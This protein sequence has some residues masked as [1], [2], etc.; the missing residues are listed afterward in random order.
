MISEEARADILAHAKEEFPNECCGVVAIVRGRERYFRCANIS[1]DPQNQFTMSPDDFAVADD[2]GEITHIAH[3]H[4]HL[5]PIPSEAD[6]VSCEA[7]G[8]PW[9]IVNP[10]TEEWG[11]CEPCGYE[12]PLVGRQHVWGVMDCWT[13]VRDWYRRE[14]SID[15]IN[16]PRRKDFWKSG[17]NPLGNNWRTAGFKKLDEDDQLETGDVILMQIG[18]SD[19]PNHVAL[20]LGDDEILHHAENRL[21]SRDVYGGWYRKHTVMVVR[22]AANNSSPG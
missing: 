1:S 19:V 6:R 13:I 9:V 18:D 22:Y 8:L 5:P 10:Q 15:L 16:V 4:I 12:A 20:Y 17:E 2:Q 7:T 14:R 3:S 21:S 11:G